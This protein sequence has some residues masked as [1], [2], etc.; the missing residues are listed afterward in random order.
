[1]NIALVNSKVYGELVLQENTNATHQGREKKKER[2]KK[3]TS[4]ALDSINVSATV[5]EGNSEY[6]L[7]ELTMEERL[8]TLTSF[9]QGSERTDAQGQSLGR[10]DNHEQS[11]SM[12]PP[13][14][15]SVHILQ[16]QALRDDDNIS[17]LNCL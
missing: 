3:R 10:N 8:A 12:A 2:A 15:D 7:D 17:L 6:N 5:N 9:N 11:L 16:R 14:V 4:S 13:S 1:M